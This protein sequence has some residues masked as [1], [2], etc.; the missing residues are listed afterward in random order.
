MGSPTPGLKGPVVA[1]PIGLYAAARIRSVSRCASRVQKTTRILR[2][3][4]CGACGTVGVRRA[5]A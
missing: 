5:I 4:D 2:F 3:R 1:G